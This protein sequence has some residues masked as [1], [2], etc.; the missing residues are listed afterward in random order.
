MVPPSLAAMGEDS[1]ELCVL[2][3]EGP[4]RHKSDKFVGMGGDTMTA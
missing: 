1:A 4:D 3:P 2:L